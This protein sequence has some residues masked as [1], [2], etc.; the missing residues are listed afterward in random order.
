MGKNTKITATAVPTRFGPTP[1]KLTV[2]IF[3]SPRLP[4][5]GLL[6]D[7]YE[8]MKW[9]AFTDYFK[10]QLQ[11]INFLFLEHHIDTDDSIKYSYIKSIPIDSGYFKIEQ[12]QD[13]Q[14]KYRFD[15]GSFFPSDNSGGYPLSDKDHLPDVLWKQMFTPD[16]PVSGWLINEVD[17]TLADKLGRQQLKKDLN[18]AIDNTIE[19]LLTAG[20]YTD[21]PDFYTPGNQAREQAKTEIA[22]FVLY[23]QQLKN[24]EPEVMLQDAIIKD[25]PVNSIHRTF[26]KNLYGALN[27]LVYEYRQQLEDLSIRISAQDLLDHNSY[28]TAEFHKKFSAYSNYPFLL[29]NTGWIWEI[30]ID[31]AGITEKM[32]ELKKFLTY[33]TSNT[34]K[35]MQLEF[36]PTPTPKDDDPM[37]LEIR[38]IL[39]SNEID[40]KCPY[41]CFELE[42]EKI[43]PKILKT[44][45]PGSSPEFG[46]E[47][48]QIERGFIKAR[49]VHTDN[50]ASY[51]LTASLIDKDQLMARI[52][53]MVRANKS[54]A[55]DAGQAGDDHANAVSVQ[56]EFKSLAAQPRGSSSGSEY[57]SNGISLSIKGIKQ[58]LNNLQNTN[59]ATQSNEINIPPTGNDQVE[60]AIASIKEGIVYAHNLHVGYRVDVAMVQGDKILMADSL[61]RRQELYCICVG[62]KH[63]W[64]ENPSFKEEGW[65]MES[66]QASQSGLTYVD[67]ELFRWN[68][69]SLVCPQIGDHEDVQHPTVDDS[70][71]A[72]LI[73]TEVPPDCSLVPLRFGSYYSF[74]LRPVDLCGNDIRFGENEATA[75]AQQLNDFWT[76]PIQYQRQDPVNTP[77][78]IPGMRIYDGYQQPDKNSDKRNLVWNDNHWGE[79]VEKMVIRSYYADGKLHTEQLSIRYIGPPKS[80]LQFALKHGL[81]DRFIKD[82]GNAEY[83]R[84]ELFEYADREIVPSDLYYMKSQGKINY[85]FD[86]VVKGFEILYERTRYA[87]ESVT[88]TTLDT[89]TDPY[90]RNWQFLKLSLEQLS[91][92]DARSP[93]DR[94]KINP[95]GS[96]TENEIRFALK[97]G[98][99]NDFQ[100]GCTYFPELENWL[101]ECVDKTKRSRMQLV[102][103][104]QKPCLIDN[105]YPDGNYFRDKVPLTILFNPDARI[106]EKRDFVFQTY[107]QLYPVY[108]ADAALLE[109]QYTDIVSDVTSSNG[110]QLKN[111]QQIVKTGLL[112]PTGAAE[113]EIFFSA[114]S[115]AFPDTKFRRV[116]FRMSIPSRFKQYFKNEKDFS[117]TGE[118]PNSPWVENAA[119]DV[120]TTIEQTRRGGWQKILSTNRPEP[121]VIERI[122]PLLSWSNTGGP[123]ATIER[124]TD[125][126][127]VYFEGDWYSSG[128][129][130][131]VAVFYSVDPGANST[132]VPVEL[133]SVISQFGTDPAGEPQALNDNSELLTLLQ[134]KKMFLG[135]EYLDHVALSGLEFDPS[136]DTTGQVYCVSGPLPTSVCAAI[137]P[138]HFSKDETEIKGR[139]FVD[140]KVSRVL[141][142]N[143]YFPF[144][145]FAL[146]RYQPNTINAKA[147]TN[148]NPKDYRFSKVTISDFVQPLP[149]RKLELKDNAPIQ[150]EAKAHRKNQHKKGTN[151]VYVFEEKLLD[152]KKDIYARLED[153]QPL[154]AEVITKANTDLVISRKNIEPNPPK[155][156]VEEYEQ[157][158][159]EITVDEKT[160]PRSDFKQRLIFSY[161]IDQ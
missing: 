57:V 117:I 161:L 39:F 146:A 20:D 1:N 132:C 29:R 141:S 38:N 94:V 3:F 92:G 16:T 134:T 15:D 58:I 111:V 31:F 61:C 127:R 144:I 60:N 128:E 116:N 154:V 133:E 43:Q 26:I 108:T 135:A 147:F 96:P 126:I 74:R 107:F 23:L 24:K 99:E 12:N 129:E 145:R 46:K 102:H 64:A 119:F 100:L 27:K 19:Q 148:D 105:Y 44:F 6:S 123:N 28:E 125:T 112:P 48:F 150:Y 17:F 140:I 124:F 62:K 157:Y 130:E 7:Y 156:V 113:K 59:P 73:I 14:I 8:I 77:V 51:E 10:T 40:I 36:K 95:G 49:P 33:P 121:I 22:S 88:R 52:G 65:L 87:V 42:V 131:Q 114:L 110:Y 63:V 9:P 78:V 103:A 86:P 76:S 37:P 72:P 69:W 153:H 106:A 118:D 56:N 18:D 4:D 151:K 66:T 84:N 25:N 75:P 53:D 89:T 50:T 45:A 139:F 34:L 71:P 80:N 138:A 152:V 35:F 54:F 101:H 137:L 5:S 81:L 32:P 93:V 90:W 104:V 67:E 82:D 30:S 55:D 115:F 155:Y 2:H 91:A 160:G 109:I 70:D 159:S 143:L 97:P 120:W 41:T 142:E 136:P 21:T 68:D 13:A 47:Y 11:G 158:E 98:V 79:D 83:I 85:L 149:Y 122:V